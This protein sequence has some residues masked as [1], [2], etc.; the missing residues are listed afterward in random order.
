MKRRPQKSIERLVRDHADLAH[1]VV[2]RCF[3]QVR[4]RTA[5]WDEYHACALEGIFQAATKFDPSKG[6]AFTTFAV[7]CASRFILTWLRKE[8]RRGI[9]Q[10]SVKKVR[11]TKL[12]VTSIAD[13]SLAAC[14]T[15][16]LDAVE[17]IAAIQR[18]V[19][20]MGSP[21]VEVMQHEFWGP[22]FSRPELLRLAKEYGY[23]SV[24]ELVTQTVQQAREV[25]C[26]KET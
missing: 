17:E 11:E 15:A 23:D 19:A 9:S 10:V 14:D 13:S 20:A 26:D 3:P 16:P 7:C 22:R 8:S 18:K 5:E 12:T 25:L 2:R 6:A 24:Q 21:F 4:P 1:W